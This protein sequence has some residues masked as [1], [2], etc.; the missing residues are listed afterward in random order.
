MQ[1]HTQNI[2]TLS[3]DTHTSYFRAVLALLHFKIKMEA[4]G[5]WEPFTRKS[6]RVLELISIYTKYLFYSV[7]KV[8]ATKYASEIF[9]GIL[10]CFLNFE[11]KSL[12]MWFKQQLL[13]WKVYPW[14]YGDIFMSMHSPEESKWDSG[15]SQLFSNKV[16]LSLIKKEKWHSDLTDAT[17]EK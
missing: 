12:F 7:K 13:P 11:D 2:Y 5:Q 8:F 1:F 4:Y 3:D 9:N 16:K 6:K 14:D 17:E 15:S 10:S